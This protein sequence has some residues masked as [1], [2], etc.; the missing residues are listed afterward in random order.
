MRRGIGR[1]EVIVIVAV[2]AGVVVIGC[3]GT[4][5]LGGLLLPAVAKA[6]QNAL[7][8]KDATQ[9]EELHTSLVIWGNA[10]FAGVFPTPSLMK[11]GG[12]SAGT[13]AVADLDEDF[14]LNHSA[15]FYSML[16]MQNYCSPELL[17]SPVEVSPH[18][19]LPSGGTDGYDWESYA[20]T[21][22]VYWDQSFVMHI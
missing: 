5:F 13:T 19:K 15:N 6:R 9:I 22:G 21:A 2:L 18:V 14:T 7:T 1:T 12:D 17:I 10:D 20:P 4:A 16:V 8:L 11:A 3:I